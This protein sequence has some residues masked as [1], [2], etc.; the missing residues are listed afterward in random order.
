[1]KFLFY[2]NLFF[3]YNILYKKNTVTEL[4][5]STQGLFNIENLKVAPESQKMKVRFESGF[6]LQNIL[7]DDPKNT[8]TCHFFEITKKVTFGTVLFSSKPHKGE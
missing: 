5:L 1:M 3:L 2:I 6:L 7:Y 8:Y 4:K